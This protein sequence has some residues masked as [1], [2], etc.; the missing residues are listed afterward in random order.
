MLFSSN[1]MNIISLHSHTL[2]HQSLEALSKSKPHARNMD[3]ARCG[4]I[5]KSRA[6]N[7]S[8]MKRLCG[9]KKY[10]AQ[11]HLGRKKTKSLTSKSA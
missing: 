2:R 1:Y 3:K 9:G 7:V 6:A 10:E 11:T 5:D 4:I 8:S